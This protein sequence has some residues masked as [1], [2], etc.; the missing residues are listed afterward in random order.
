MYAT[1]IYLFIFK[2]RRFDGYFLFQ[3]GRID[4]PPSRV[5]VYVHLGLPSHQQQKKQ[6]PKLKNR[7]REWIN[8]F[9]LIYINTA[10][11]KMF[12][13]YKRKMAN[14]QRMCS[15]CV[16]VSDLWERKKR[17]RG[18]GG[19]IM[20]WYCKWKRVYLFLA[21]SWTAGGYLGTRSYTDK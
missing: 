16:C 13:L 11:K 20:L 9:L 5:C 10:K 2:R 8:G 1:H 17:E 18:G 4:P 19:T 14:W 12:I 21:W 3:S 6:P 15:V 7:T